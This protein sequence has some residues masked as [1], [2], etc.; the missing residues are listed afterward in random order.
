MSKSDAHILLVF[1]YVMVACA[2][3]SVYETWQGFLVLGVCMI[4]HGLLRLMYSGQSG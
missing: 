1:G 4:G 3:G 2:I